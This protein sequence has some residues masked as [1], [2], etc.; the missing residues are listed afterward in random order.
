MILRYML[1]YYR[2]VSNRTVTKTYNIYEKY[3]IFS[4][5]LMNYNGMIFYLL[6]IYL[7]NYKSL[8]A[9]FSNYFTNINLLHMRGNFTHFKIPIPHPLPSSNHQL[10]L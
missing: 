9:Y 3:L 7:E 8:K 5:I 6:K 10:V 4:T 1:L 2:I